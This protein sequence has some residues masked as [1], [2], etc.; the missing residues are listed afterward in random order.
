MTR[1]AIELMKLGVSGSGVERLLG[2]HDLDEIERQLAYLPFRKAKRPEAFIIEAVRN[3]YSTPK[4]FYHAK[5]QA[6][7][8]GATNPLDTDTKRAARHPHAVA[9]GHR[10]AGAA[11][12]LAP[13]GGLEQGWP[14][15]HLAIP[16]APGSDGP[17]E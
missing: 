16:D 14:D 17:A 2:H 5:T 4:G 11:R 1:L 7:T 8:P 3:R 10:T 6:H 9:Q 13:D 15:G 12:P